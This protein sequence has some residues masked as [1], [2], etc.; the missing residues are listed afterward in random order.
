MINK[1]ILLDCVS[2][3]TTLQCIAHKCETGKRAKW[4]QNQI[5]IIINS[6]SIKFLFQLEGSNII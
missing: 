6:I 5:T 3:K 2:Y 4:T 1:M